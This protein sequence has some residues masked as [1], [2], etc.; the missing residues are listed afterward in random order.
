MVENCDNCGACCMGQNLLPLT[1]NE[2]D[3]RVLIVEAK[4]NADGA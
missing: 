1:G 4:E 3:G 2:L